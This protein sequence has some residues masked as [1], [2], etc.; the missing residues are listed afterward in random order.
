MAIVILAADQVHARVISG[1]DWEKMEETFDFVNFSGRGHDDARVTARP[2]R[3]ATPRGVFSRG[4]S[5]ENGSRRHSWEQFSAH[6][7]EYCHQLEIA[8]EI[9]MLCVVSPPRFLGILRKK[10]RHIGRRLPIRYVRKDI[11]DRSVADIVRVAH[12]E[13]KVRPRG[14][15]ATLAWREALAKGGRMSVRA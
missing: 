10:L 15:L 11:L 3:Y 4:I 5:S 14:E 6:M 12:G 8:G 2:G 7:A 13:S 1:K 9:D